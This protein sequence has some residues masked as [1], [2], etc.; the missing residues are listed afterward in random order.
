MLKLHAATFI[1]LGQTRYQRLARL[2]RSPWL[3]FPPLGWFLPH[4]S[5]TA[6]IPTLVLIGG[7]WFL[8]SGFLVPVP[9]QSQSTLMLEWAESRGWAQPTETS[10]LLL[11]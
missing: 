7:F 1:D 3:L 11:P 10:L 9:D 8:A 5:T 6:S 2:Q 4:S